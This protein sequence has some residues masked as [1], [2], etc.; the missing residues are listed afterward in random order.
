MLKKFTYYAIRI[1]RKMTIICQK[2]MKFSRNMPNTPTENEDTDV[3]ALRIIMASRRNIHVN[4]DLW[5]WLKFVPQFSVFQPAKLGVGWQPR[6]VQYTVHSVT[7][8]SA[9][10]S[11][12]AFLVSSKEL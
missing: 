1:S 11:V 6:T 4:V 9:R 3:M 5:L 10:S 12:F 8:A 7:S 2:S